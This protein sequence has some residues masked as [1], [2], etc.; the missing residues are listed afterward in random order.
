[1]NVDRPGCC[2][3]PLLVGDRVV[4]TCAERWMQPVQTVRRLRAVS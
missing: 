3:Y 4:H 1:M 2:A